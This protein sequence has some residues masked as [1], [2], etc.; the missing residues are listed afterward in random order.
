[1]SKKAG[2]QETAAKAANAAFAA[3]ETAA[4]LPARL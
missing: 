3:L 2:G 1:M 4:R